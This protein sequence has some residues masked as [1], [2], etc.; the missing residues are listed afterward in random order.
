MKSSKPS[1]GEDETLDS[2]YHGRIL[3]LQKKQGY[4]FSV[5]APL[6]AD[7]IRTRRGDRLLELG[8]G[9]GIISLL[10]GRKFFRRI[11]CLEVQPSLAD[12]ARRNVVLNQLEKKIFVLEQ[13]L[14]AFRPGRKFD[15][16]FSNP[17]YIKSRGGHLSRSEE[18]SIAK[19]EIKGDIF[20][21]MQAAGR[22]LKKDGRA[23]FIYPVK[24]RSDFDRA[25]EE[26][27]LKIKTLR[28][29]H[30]RSGEP[31]RWFLSECRFEAPSAAVLPPLWVHD[32]RGAYTP[33]MKAI[34]AGEDRD[35]HL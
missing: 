26:P 30:S 8:A 16:V 10:L 22:A 18:K 25:L 7:F 17:P 32:E 5:D 33:E 14:R 29:V 1:P 19:H 35:P 12:L 4:R 34:F 13:D 9:N 20:D 28:F 3:L 2:F 11:V 6:L 21:I 27:G 31:A 23:C 15:L 24:R